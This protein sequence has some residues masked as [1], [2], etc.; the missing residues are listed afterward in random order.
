METRT[1]YEKGITTSRL[2]VD[3]V[4]ATKKNKFKN[5]GPTRVLLLP[6]NIMVP[7]F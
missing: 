2:I 5:G 4:N 3:I 6:R 1:K 7:H